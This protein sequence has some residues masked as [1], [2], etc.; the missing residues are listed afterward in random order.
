MPVLTAAALR[1][2]IASGE[3]AP[4]YAL[5]GADEV[6]KSEVAAQFIDMVDEGLRAFNVDRLYGG[7][8]KVDEV[9]DSANTLP[10]MVPRRVVVILEAEK[11]LIP[12]RESKA[13]EEEQE[14]LEAFLNDPSPHSTVV[15]A[16]GGLDMR[17]R[18]VK[19][20]LKVAQ[21]VDSGTIED[22]ADAERWLKARAARD[23]VTFEP[24]AARALVERAGLD[25][26]RLRAGF[27]RVVL[28]AMG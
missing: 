7:E 16:C 28:Y 5:I 11:L 19:L 9:I 24:A 12:K 21:V 6:E 15:F 26:A 18:I 1:K 20:L 25:V 14:R 4:L 3:T 2:Q 27:D 17:R 10:M 13:A 23:K 8:A 22:E